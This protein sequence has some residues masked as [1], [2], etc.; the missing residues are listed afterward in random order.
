MSRVGLYESDERPRQCPRCKATDT[1]TVRVW[2]TGMVRHRHRI[3]K[4]CGKLFDT[5]TPL[6]RDEY[7]AQPNPRIMA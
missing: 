7:L 1:R 2:M 4:A 6:T 3:C 5:A